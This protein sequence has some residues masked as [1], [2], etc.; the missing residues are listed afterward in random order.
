VGDVSPR[1]LIQI[2]SPFNLLIQRP[3]VDGDGNATSRDSNVA[4]RHVSSPI[5]VQVLI[6]ALHCVGFD[7]LMPEGR[8]FPSNYVPRLGTDLGITI[9]DP[10]PHEKFQSI[11][12][13]WRASQS[14]R[15]DVLLNAEQGS[16][17]PAA[18]LELEKMTVRSALT[19]V[20]Q[21]AVEELGRS[22]SGPL[23]GAPK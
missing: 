11:I 3:H 15:A 1:A 6:Y 23:L 2:S 19:A 9:G 20:A 21:D 12:T 4:A 13:E 14:A 18:V 7:R 10:I 17:D 16:A 22:V 5:L 8:R